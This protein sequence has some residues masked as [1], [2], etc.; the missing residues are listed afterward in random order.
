MK[1]DVL[2]QFR[3]PYSLSALSLRR[4]RDFSR[5]LLRRLIPT[6][7]DLGVFHYALVM[8]S[9]CSRYALVM[10]WLCSRYVVVGGGTPRWSIERSSRRWGAEPPVGLLS[11]ASGVGGR[12]P[13]SVV[14]GRTPPSLG[15]GT[16]PGFPV[17]R[18]GV[19]LRC[20]GVRR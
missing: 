3:R 15:G 10:L 20:L 17:R 5:S 6:A 16:P 7:G 18:F 14:G 9:L 4:Y 11:V 13:P 19:R 1:G 8:L 12:T 2:L